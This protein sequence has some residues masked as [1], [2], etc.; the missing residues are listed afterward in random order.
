MQHYYIQPADTQH[1]YIQPAD[2]QH[3]YIQSADMQAEMHAMSVIV[4]TL[5]PQNRMQ[6][7]SVAHP[8]V[9]G[10]IALATMPGITIRNNGSSLRYPA[11]TKAPCA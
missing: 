7:S 8:I 10:N 3:Y 2:M 1:Y 11:N 4:S 5:L 6:A 9:S